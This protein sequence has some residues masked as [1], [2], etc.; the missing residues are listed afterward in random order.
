VVADA[1]GALTDTTGSAE[2]ALH[3]ESLAQAAAAPHAAAPPQ[4]AA[5]G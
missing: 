3:A 5:A 1:E 4:A 2:L